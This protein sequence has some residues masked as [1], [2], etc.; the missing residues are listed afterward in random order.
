MPAKKT[1]KG[2]RV[3]PA[4]GKGA[5]AA[6]SKGQLAGKT[7]AARARKAG[8][9]KGAR[10]TF[11]PGGAKGAGGSDPVATLLAL[12][13]A[14][15]GYDDAM[16]A[17]GA[18]GVV[19]LRAL[20]QEAG[21]APAPAAKLGGLVKLIAA[22]AAANEAKADAAAE[23]AR[24]K[25][26]TLIPKKKTLKL[27]EEVGSSAGHDNEVLSDE[28]DASDAPTPA[29]RRAAAGGGWSTLASL[30][31]AGVITSYLADVVG[32]VCE[33]HDPSIV[34]QVLEA[35][36][37]YI[38][39]PG[40]VLEV[41]ER[42]AVVLDVAHLSRFTIETKGGG[43]VPL[44]ATTPFSPPRL[45]LLAAMQRH[46]IARTPTRLEV[47][48]ALDFDTVF[49]RVV[50]TVFGVVYSPQVM[51]TMQKEYAAQCKSVATEAAKAAPAAG[52]PLTVPAFAVLFKGLR[53]AVDEV[54][55]LA[56]A[57][58][59]N[60][61]QAAKI[62]ASLRAD[63]P[64]MPSGRATE[65][66]QLRAPFD[67]A[68]N[69][70][71]ARKYEGM[72]METSGGEACGVT[73]YDA[74]TTAVKEGDAEAKAFSTAQFLKCVELLVFT[75]FVV[76]SD[77]KD[78]DGSVPRFSLSSAQRAVAA[79]KRLAALSSVTPAMY[80]G[81]I[82]Q[83]YEKAAQELEER[84]LDAPIPKDG[85]VGGAFVVFAKRILEMVDQYALSP[86][87][88]PVVGAGAPPVVEPAPKKPR[89]AKT[90]ASPA[91]GGGAGGARPVQVRMPGGCG[92]G[93]AACTNKNH[94]PAQGG[95]PKAWCGLDHTA[96]GEPQPDAAKL[97]ELQF[98]V[99]VQR[100]TAA[101]QGVTFKKKK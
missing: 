93:Y 14:D 12:S 29:K 27:H 98:K 33:G 19:E 65:Y 96:F 53:S 88:A 73:A 77:I 62:A 72:V 6:R 100:A 60:D 78:G 51:K 11:A 17:Y 55:Y 43:K 71:T 15:D 23:L 31:A 45:E 10:V 58:L 42:S 3:R 81:V 90:S 48:A 61:A 54:V 75:S 4:A 30:Q 34:V 79:A 18:T 91:G 68:G 67:E 47:A 86:A 66:Q 22:H 101:K 99:S 56:R 20:C 95:N 94:D 63:Q 32:A 84:D 41:G 82:K 80:T 85:L 39:T 92:S 16:R 1:K 69:R 57:D 8:A 38:H 89:L 46:L 64:V 76:V 97:K 37:P 25:E 26:R 7:G 21:L 70:V 2:A 52:A 44:P 24:P 59:A 5:S 28:S 36:R 13:A 87:R 40:T 74:E 35:F 83:A 49:D 50:E 9:G